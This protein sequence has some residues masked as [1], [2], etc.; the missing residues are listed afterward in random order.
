VNT[1][2]QAKFIRKQIPAG[3]LFVGLEWRIKTPA[4]LRMKGALVF[5]HE[6]D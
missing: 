6:R 1:A 3:G 2:D 5:L 4:C